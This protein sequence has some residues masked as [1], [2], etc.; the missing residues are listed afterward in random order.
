MA[1]DAARQRMVL[2]GGDSLGGTLFGDTWEWDGAHWTQVED[3]GPGARAGH[4]MAYDS[5]RSRVVLFGGGVPALRGETW[6]WDGQGWTQVED[7]GPEPRQGHGLVYDGG[8]SRTVLFGGEASGSVL[9][10][11]TWEW[12]GQGWTQVQDTGPTPRKSHAMA[13]AGGAQGVLLYGGETD[14][15][16]GVADTW[17]WNGT[18][19]TQLEDIGPGPLTDS[20]AAAVGNGVLL[21]GGLAGS[22][23]S[24]LTW[25]WDG[26]HWTIRQDIGP[27]PRWGHAAALDSS[28]GRVVLFGGASVAPN[29]AAVADH[30]LGD[31]WEEVDEGAGAP[32]PGGGV[33]LVSF[34]ITPDTINSAGGGAIMLEVAIDQPAPSA[35]TVTIDLFSV[36]I[37]IAPGTTSGS[38]NANIPPG[39]A[40]PGDYPVQA[41][42][43]SQSKV[44]TL[45]VT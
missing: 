29:D 6:E 45:H 38:A 4:A 8:R 24:G 33:Q 13:I 27:G 34:T 37:T 5:G 20:A 15:G 43:G 25:Q 3:T 23:V 35:V 28:R 30:L 41:L 7:T 16:T 39:A 36:G 2:F 26:Q 19:W 9:R 12:D 14:G 17:A 42:L 31:T 22:G 44:A 32:P 18:S 21:F 1:F 10:G 11:E 40:P